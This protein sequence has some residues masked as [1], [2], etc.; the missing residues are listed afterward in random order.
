[1]SFSVSG[2]HDVEPDE[3]ETTITHGYSKGHRLDL[4][5]AV[6][7]LVTSQNGGIPLMMKCFGGNASDNKIF[8]ERCKEL[9]NLF[10]NSETPRYFVGDS[11]LY[12]EDNA[13]NLSEITFITRIPR[14]YKE[15]NKAITAA[16][17]ANHWTLFDEE[18]KYYVHTTRHFDIQQ[19]WVVV[20]SNSAKFRSEKTLN[21]RIEKEYRSA[22]SVLLHLRNKE[23]GCE[24]DA[25][26]ELKR[27]SSNYFG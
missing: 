8:K 13:C 2:E 21:K 4:K 26:K 7:E 12:H 18:N 10:K 24:H 9:M 14:T 1:M 17:A 6:L 23:F 15:E 19:S 11:K 25:K 5:Q 20:H 27:L 3:N 16:I 22:E